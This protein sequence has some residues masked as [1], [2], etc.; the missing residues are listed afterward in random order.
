MPLLDDMRREAIQNLPSF[1]RTLFLLHNFYDFDVSMM[2]QS[3][4]ADRV[5][6]LACLAEARSLVYRYRRDA[7]PERFDPADA[8]LPIARLERRLREEYRAGLEAVFAGCGYRGVV[9]WPDPSTD[10]TADEEAAAAFILSSLPAPLRKAVAASR[11]PDTPTAELW[12]FALP[13]RRILRGHLLH[14]ANEIHCSGWEPFDTWLANRIAPDR[15]YPH[16]YAEYRRLRRPSPQELDPPQEEWSWPHWPNDEERQQ[17]F[18]SLPDLT[19]G[20]YVLFHLYGRNS[21]EI[22]QRLGISRRSVQRRIRRATYNMAGW[23]LP[24]LFSALRF[25]LDWRWDPMKRQS[26]GVWAALRD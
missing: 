14:I 25:E 20:A 15:H 16:G 8:G 6:V 23:P 21:P 5:E 13:W 1:P 22:A 2:V 3:L 18:D 7:R 24:S 11:R 9:A 12:R 4:A 17:R 26:R 19:Q 10:I